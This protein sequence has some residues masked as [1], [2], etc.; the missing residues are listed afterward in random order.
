MVSLQQGGDVDL[1]LTPVIP[2]S[3]GDDADFLVETT[4]VMVMEYRRVGV[5][6]YAPADRDEENFEAELVVGYFRFFFFT[7]KRELGWCG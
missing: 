1:V 7:K 6:M 5:D 4:M 2:S 3:R